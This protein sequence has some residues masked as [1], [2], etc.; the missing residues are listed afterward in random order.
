MRRSKEDGEWKRG[1]RKKETGDG[2]QRRIMLFHF[3]HR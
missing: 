3:I 2:R 1:E